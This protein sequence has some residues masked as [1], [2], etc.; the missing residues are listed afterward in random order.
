M[1][2]NNIGT[3]RYNTTK[4]SRLVLHM[5]VT[6]KGKYKDFRVR[7]ASLYIEKK[8]IEHCEQAWLPS[9]SGSPARFL[10]SLIRMPGGSKVV[11]STAKQSKLSQVCIVDPMIRGLSL[12]MLAKAKG[13]IMNYSRRRLPNNMV[14]RW[15]VYRTHPQQSIWK[16]KFA[17]K[18]TLLLQ[19]T[20]FSKFTT[21]QGWKWKSNRIIP[22]R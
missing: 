5:T 17:W 2:C 12:L 8:V 22:W 15:K 20:F 18:F 7:F 10:T 3:D 21:P 11:F 9:T 4:V 1:K 14:F 16:R 6:V 13:S 19:R